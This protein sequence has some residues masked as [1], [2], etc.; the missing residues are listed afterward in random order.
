M[1]YPFRFLAALLLVRML[2]VSAVSAQS[3][4]TG[5]LGRLVVQAGP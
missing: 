3:A 5:M 1:R 4:D 2:S